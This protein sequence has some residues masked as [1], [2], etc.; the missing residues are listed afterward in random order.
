MSTYKLN[1]RLRICP[2]LISRSLRK[3]AGLAV[4]T[5]TS[6]KSATFVEDF[7]EIRAARRLSET[8]KNRKLFQE[9]SLGYC[10][11]DGY[12]G[13]CVL[14]CIMFGWYTGG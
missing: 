12:S 13:C 7:S 2:E 6:E 10:G 3:N 14:G 11:Q 8:T 1:Q 5:L 9:S 4:Q